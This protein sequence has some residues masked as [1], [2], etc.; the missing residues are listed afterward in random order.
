VPQQTWDRIWTDD[1]L[2]K[3]YSLT[4]DEISFIERMIRPMGDAD[5]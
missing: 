3:K 5:E 1:E 2:F 4:D